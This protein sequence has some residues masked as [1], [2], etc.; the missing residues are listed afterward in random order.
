MAVLF[1]NTFETGLADGTAITVANSDDGTAGNPFNEVNAGVGGVI[2]FDTARVAHGSLA[3]R[4]VP[5]VS[6]PCFANAPFTSDTEI[7]TRIYLYLTTAI[8][9]DMW[10][11]DFNDAGGGGNRCGLVV[12]GSDDLLYVF[13]GPLGAADSS[14]ATVPNGQWVRIETRLLT[15]ATTGLI[16]ARMFVGESETMLDNAILPSTNT[17]GDVDW[18]KTGSGNPDATI[19][20]FSLD[21]FVVVDD[22]WPG[23]F[24]TGS[25]PDTGHILRP[26]MVL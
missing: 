26:A 13:N 11:H 10:L 20:E 9:D 4:Y 14:T 5:A 24:D 8:A 16:E 21:S 17:S 1:E 6:T 23:P 22:D 7:F 12:I 2:E 25:P 19:P 15:H 3:A 18:V